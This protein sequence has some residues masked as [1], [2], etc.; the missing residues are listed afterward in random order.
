MRT[1][2]LVYSVLLWYICHIEFGLSDEENLL[3]ITGPDGHALII[4]I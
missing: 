2:Q 4:T 1:S 3:R